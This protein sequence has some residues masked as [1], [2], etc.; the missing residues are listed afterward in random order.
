[1]GRKA[2]TSKETAIDVLLQVLHLS[3]LVLKVAPSLFQ[4][5][6][7]LLVILTLLFLY[8][9]ELPPRFESTFVRSFYPLFNLRRQTVRGHTFF[10]LSFHLSLLLSRFIYPTVCVLISVATLT[11]RLVNIFHFFTLVFKPFRA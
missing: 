8:H 6:L 10:K 5:V 9:L 11:N 7:D 1:M 2:K 4:F 3:G